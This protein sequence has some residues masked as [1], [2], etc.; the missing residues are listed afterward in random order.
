[1]NKYIDLI[2]AAFE[3]DLPSGDVTTDSL[4]LEPHIGY[5]RVVAKE[6][7]YLSGQDIFAETVGFFAPETD[8]Q[9]HFKS[10][11]QVLRGQNICS[12][13]GDLL[14]SLKLERVALNFLGH[15]SGIATL[16][17]K[18]V[19]E[20][21]HTQ[22]QILDTRKT[23]PGWRCLEKQAVKDGGGTN[24][25]M[26]LSEAV[27]IKENH[28]RVAGGITQ[29]IHRIRNN[30]QGPIE[31]EV[32]NLS[33]LREAVECRPQRVLLDNMDN[34]T[35]AD[36]LKI[37]PKGIQTEASGNM[38]LDR[39]KSVAEIGVDYISVGAL[40]HS[41]PCADISMLFEWETALKPGPQ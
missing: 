17:H 3:E 18:F 22:T 15:L 25:R 38:S 6:D 7:L 9:W 16:T 21:E 40:T 30:H 14:S 8:I 13:K 20:V 11:D 34:A 41:A 12:L 23:L 10:G 31:I 2:K 32:S 36:A 37:I 19:A 5:A 39:V 29:A 24:H 35:L 33:E 4:K 27:L 28:I 1:M 26:N